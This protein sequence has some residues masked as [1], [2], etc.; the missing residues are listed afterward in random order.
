MK[1][2]LFILILL[3]IIF[4]SC[5]CDTEPKIVELNYKNIVILSDM[6][7]R[8]KKCEPKDEKII[9]SIIEY[10]KT[11]CVKPGQKI[12]DNS[13]I[14][15]APFSENE[16]YKIDIGLYKNIVDKQNFVN[17]TGK[18]RKSGLQIK[19]SELKK[20]VDSTYKN[21]SDIGLDLIS[22]LIDKIENKA[23]LKND[24]ILTVGVDTTKIKYDNHIYIFTDGYLE[25]VSSI[26][27]N[28]Q[29]MFGDKEIKK[30][31]AYCIQNNIDVI[32]ALKQ[33]PDLGLP[34]YKSEKFKKIT[35][36]IM[37]THQRD[38]NKNFNRFNNKIGLLD[39]QILEAVWKKWARDSGFKKLFWDTY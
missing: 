9:D 5:G 34:S 24:N 11:E 21:K 31:R 27:N 35:L 16:F 13:C 26:N 2:K 14:S 36:H 4:N 39:N 22:L 18:Y 32:T 3:F 19:I 20:I 30:L 10:F 28:K 8:L 37:E 29:F 25:Y 15:F 1:N 38:F 6:S 23:I 12:G 33:R 7:N 17:S